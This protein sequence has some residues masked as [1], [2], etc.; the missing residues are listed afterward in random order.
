MIAY[1]SLVLALYLEILL[2]SCFGIKVVRDPY[3]PEFG[4]NTEI[5]GK[6]IKKYNHEKLFFQNMRTRVF[7]DMK[8]ALG[9]HM[10]S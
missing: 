10:H 7:P 3:F 4:L 2:F 6:K 5:Y 1:G 8:L 9:N